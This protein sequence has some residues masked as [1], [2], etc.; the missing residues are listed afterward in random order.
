MCQEPSIQTASQWAMTNF[1]S[2]D[3]GDA[4]RTKRAVQIAERMA[5]HPGASSPEQMPAWAELKACYRF[6]DSAAVTFDALAR[7]HWEQTCATASGRVLILNDTTTISYKTQRKIDG[8]T[9]GGRGM[10]YGFQLHNALMV[11][12]DDGAVLGLARQELFYRVPA[13]KKENRHQR[14]RRPRETD[15]WGRVIDAIGI[16]AAGVEYIH[17]CDRGADNLEVFCHLQQQRCQWVIRC[18]HLHRDVQPVVLA[19]LAPAISVEQVLA[20]Q[21]IKGTTTLTLRAR[22]GQAART[23]ELAL[24][25]VEVSI[26]QP[27]NRTP[28]L[29]DRDFRGLRQTLVE[30]REV[31]PPQG[32]TPLRWVL[33]TSLPVATLRDALD[34]AA[35]YEQRWLIEELHKAM[36][37]GCQLEDRQYESAHS[38]EGVAGITSV[39][40]VRL[41]ALKQLARSAPDT[42][43]S[44]VVPH[45]WL[46]MLE[47]LRKRPLPTVRDFVRHLAGLGGFLMRKGDGEPGWLTLW[48]GAE[49]LTIALKTQ[50]A[51]RRRCG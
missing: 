47:T 33:W 43:A 50:A 49:R 6:F 12:A 34:I 14:G 7:P 5:D 51:L 45:E 17:V 2:C 39:L 24:R 22:P 36:K 44:N 35:I 9:R 8:F 13:P 28:Y 25:V 11:D 19:G 29:R 18:S 1:G 40:A 10:P 15:V 16:P 32:V 23:A 3:L 26:P 21:P 41:L 46:R 20:G 30:L 38:L 48:R 27:R 37:T 31:R 42:P 4:R